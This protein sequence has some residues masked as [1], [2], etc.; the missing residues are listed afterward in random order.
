MIFW[1][2]VSKKPV[3]E[4]NQIK[5]VAEAIKPNKIQ[6][7]S[8]K[9]SDRRKNKQNSAVSSNYDKEIVEQ[10][11]QHD[12]SPKDIKKDINSDKPKS[13]KHISTK[14]SPENKGT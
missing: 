2:L 12:G 1:K 4:D 9:N 14:E 3:V 6:E 8:N 11:E 10:L 13:N 7:K 5:T